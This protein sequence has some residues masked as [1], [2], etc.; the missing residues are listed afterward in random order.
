MHRRTQLALTG[1][2]VV[3]ATLPL[4]YLAAVHVAPIHWLDAAILKGFAN[5]NGPRVEPIAT[6]L[7]TLCDPDM[8]V[9]FAAALVAIALLRR[10]P[11]T[12]VAVFVVLLGANVTTQL[13]KPALATPRYSSLL[14]EIGQIAAVS[15]PSG[16]ATASMAIALCAILVAPAAWRPW[17]G[18]LGAIFAVAVTFSFLTLEW[19]YPSDVLGG[20]L[21][22]T[23]WTL[24]AVAVLSWSEQRWPLARD[25]A[26]RPSVR[27]ALAP[28][29]IATACASLL[30]GVVLLARPDQVVS[31]AQTHT[32]FVIGAAALA[33]AA[34]MLA[35]GVSLLL[36]RAPR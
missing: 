2:L 10:R 24:A 12:A 20:F 11:R 33:A 6:F 3:A 17:V 27:E 16:H 4:V 28:A 15:W 8:F 32:T 21:V 22:S 19:H 23:A 25:R 9:W 30:A 29:A 18:A 5:L 35:A 7:A 14:E 36:L 1:A 31:Y 13:L 26:R 34:L